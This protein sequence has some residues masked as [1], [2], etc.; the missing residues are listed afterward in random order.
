MTLKMGLNPKPGNCNPVLFALHLTVP[1]L[2]KLPFSIQVANIFFYFSKVH[3]FLEAKL[4]AYIIL[5]FT[6]N[7]KAETPRC[8]SSEYSSYPSSNG[9]RTQIR[10]QTIK[11]LTNKSRAYSK[12]TKGRSILLLLKLI[13]VLNVHVCTGFRDWFNLL[14]PCYWLAVIHSLP[15]FV[16]DDYSILLES[17]HLFLLF[18]ASCLPEGTVNEN[19][20]VKKISLLKVS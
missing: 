11:E 7:S 5:S 20:P 12:K 6:G 2:V 9:W 1:P 15:F 18:R 16:L 4:I 10:K 3:I 8:H 17:Y 13:V 19:R 14:S